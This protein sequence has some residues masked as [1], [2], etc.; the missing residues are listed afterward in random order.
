MW[1]ERSGNFSEIDLVKETTGINLDINQKGI[2]TGNYPANIPATYTDGSKV[3]P[4]LPGY[5]AK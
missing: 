3:K 4:F 5:Y 2:Y 1:V